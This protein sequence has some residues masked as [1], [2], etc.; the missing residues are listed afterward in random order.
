[1]KRVFVK[2][3]LAMLAMGLLTACSSSNDIES[4]REQPGQ[5]QLG[6]ADPKDEQEEQEPEAQEPDDEVVYM[7][8]QTRAIELTQ[9]QRAF[10]KKNN[11]FTFNFYRTLHAS[12][13]EKKSNV[14][15][16]LSVTYVMG[17]LNDGATGKTSEEIT[18]VLGFGDGDKTALNAYCQAFITQAPLADP[19]VTLEMADIVAADDDVV[20]EDQYKKDM[21]DYYEAEVT[22]LDFADPASLDY[23]NGWCNEKS[24]GMIPEI[25]DELS[26][27]VKLV[28]MNAIYFKASWTEKFDEK[29]TKVETFTKADGTNVQVPMMKRNADI[30]YNANDIFSSVC[31]PFG[32]GDRYLMYVLLPSEGKTVDDVINA[33]T[34]DYWEQN[35]QG[36]PTCVKLS[37]PRFETDSDFKLNEIISQMGAPTMFDID[38]AE[39]PNMSQNYKNLYVSLMKQKAAIEV[40]E[41]GAKASAVT[42]AT[43]E[44][45]MNLFDKTATFNANR[46]FVYLIQEWDTGAIFFIGTFQGD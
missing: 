19:S 20:F 6:Q 44:L 7:L 2:A 17:M 1:M 35:R 16:P 32:T 37:L 10:A 11:D 8:P 3:G 13:Q 45:S 22:S 14:T 36:E 18:N 27:E 26:P 12:Q 40:S 34:N 43:M 41:E 31:L 33:L 25:L 29:D 46:P 42:V 39:F 21:Q 24:H 28:L 5:E 4:V 15:S 23:L 38:K 30:L 9:E